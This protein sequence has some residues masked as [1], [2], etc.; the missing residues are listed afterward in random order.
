MLLVGASMLG[1]PKKGGA[2]MLVIAA[3]C[4]ASPFVIQD[5]VNALWF[6]IGVGAVIVLSA[7]GFLIEVYGHHSH[8]KDRLTPQ[9]KQAT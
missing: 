3:L 7:I 1:L 2:I 5:V 8:V 9:D 4:F 6:K